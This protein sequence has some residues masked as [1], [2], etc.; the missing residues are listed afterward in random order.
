MKKIIAK[1]VH[2]TVFLI[3]IFVLLG[4]CLLISF[5]K[6]GNAGNDEPEPSEPVGTASDN[7]P[8]ASVSETAPPSENEVSGSV[9][10]V[11]IDPPSDTVPE[12]TAPEQSGNDPVTAVPPVPE[13]PRYDYCS[14]VAEGPRM[15]DDY[16]SDAVF[17]GDSRTDGF[18]LYSGLNT[19]KYLSA[20][21]ISVV[22]I[23][24]ERVIPAGGDTYVPIL[25]ALSW[26]SYSKVYI[27]LGINE[28]GLSP[29]AFKDYYEKVVE[30]V[31]EIQPEAII[32]LQAIM[33]VSAEK[34]KEKSVYNN[35][36][37]RRFNNMIA[38]L[39]S[40][41]LVYFIDTYFALGDEYGVLPPDASYDG[42]HPTGTYCKLWCEYLRTHT[43]DPSQYA[44]PYSY[45]HDEIFVPIYP[46]RVEPEPE[47]QTG[48]EIQAEPE[49]QSGNELQ[50]DPE[51][52]SA[53]PDPE[54]IPPS[55]ASTEPSGEGTPADSTAGDVPTVSGSGPLTPNA[56]V[57]SMPSEN[58]QNRD[59]DNSSASA[60]NP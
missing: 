11:I 2:I 50:A 15:D 40:E 23:G 12:G 31:K 7:A 42:V 13:L 54:A 56:S 60:V 32:Y 19:P 30:R 17:L 1:R 59:I 43:V 58:E 34:E 5:T 24:T 27:M 36:N 33:P 57:E 3:I 35:Y 20:K 10:P 49:P 44:D 39:A 52:Q 4:A 45:T 26:Q 9:P 21:S 53:Q 25:T 38:E 6:N 46:E 47:P 48:N 51:P 55:Q 41:Q 16:F 22:N 37:I 28:I 18:R 29:S 14:P 8:Q